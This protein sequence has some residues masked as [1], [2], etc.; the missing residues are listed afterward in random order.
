MP[1]PGAPRPNALRLEDHRTK[2]A[3]RS[4]LDSPA[5]RLAS[6]QLPLRPTRDGEKG[7]V[8]PQGNVTFKNSY[9]LVNTLPAFLPVAATGTYR[10]KDYLTNPSHH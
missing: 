7:G 1:T 2:T 4:T 8:V 5:V 3:P 9:L 10:L 6:T